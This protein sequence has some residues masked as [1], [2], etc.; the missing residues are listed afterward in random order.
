MV[1]PVW[2]LVQLRRLDAPL[3]PK[4]NEW[5]PAHRDALREP[6]APLAKLGPLPPGALAFRVRGYCGAY[7]WSE[8]SAPSEPITVTFFGRWSE[9]MTS[10]WSSHRSMVTVLSE[11]GS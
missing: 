11:K 10:T 9:P 4:A 3:E 8:W 2:P 6:L 1:Q 5:Q 7:G